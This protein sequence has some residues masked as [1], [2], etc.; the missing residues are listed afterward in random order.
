MGRTVKLQ[1]IIAN[2]EDRFFEGLIDP[3]AFKNSKIRYMNRIKS[4]EDKMLT[5]KNSI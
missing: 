4:H 2:A 3:E 1:N 5:L